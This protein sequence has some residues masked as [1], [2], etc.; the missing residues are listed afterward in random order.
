M[1]KLIS[2]K[3]IERYLNRKD[4][5]IID[6]RDREDYESLHIN[7]AVNMDYNSCININNSRLK[8]KIL[9]LYCDKGNLSLKAGVKLDK[10]GYNVIS[11]GGGFE[12][13][14][15]YYGN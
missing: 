12:G 9:L 4:V 2:G 7:G 3:E 8:Q 15:S 13:I 1:L 5:L 11:V 6:L 10:K 14:K